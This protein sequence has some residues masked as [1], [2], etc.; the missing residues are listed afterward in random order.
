[1]EENN[2]TIDW[3]AAFYAAL[4]LEFWEYRNILEI[5]DEYVLLN[6]PLK[7]DCVVIK[8][9]L[10]IEIENDI[11]K[12]FHTYN[13]VEYKSPDDEL[14]IEVFYKSI[15]YACLYI[16]SPKH[17][18]APEMKELSITLV[19]DKYP[20]KLFKVLRQNDFDVKR[21][22][23]GIYH[24]IG[25]TFC[26]IQIIISSELNQ[27]NHIHLRALTK[28][29]D[30]MIYCK[31]LF[32]IGTYTGKAKELADIEMQAIASAHKSLISSFKE[33]E[34]MC[35]AL[36]EIMKDELMEERKAGENVGRIEGK[37]EGKII[38]L[39]DLI[40]DNLLTIEQGAERLNM[41]RDEFIKTLGKYGY[42]F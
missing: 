9:V 23:D 12:I 40:K 25:K 13:I 39:Y 27:S 1:M 28:K 16:V 41:T 34:I 4:R 10:N 7:I 30:S 35:E 2:N 17:T 18:K 5:L 31:Y 29:M 8:K 24:I 20:Q 6:R 22:K 15:A 33:D 11:A 37:I 38:L 14:D 36:R 3:H 42:N 26:D 32:E 19:R 21:Y